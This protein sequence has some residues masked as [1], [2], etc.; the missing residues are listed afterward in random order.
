MEKKIQDRVDGRL[1]CQFC[2]SSY[3]YRKGLVRHMRERHPKE[4]EA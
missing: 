2:C 4:W 1:H 3:K